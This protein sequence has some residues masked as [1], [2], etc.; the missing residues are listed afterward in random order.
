M[1]NIE[2]LGLVAAVFTTSSFFP[3]VYKAWKEKSTKDISLTMYIAFLI[4]I[5]L[6]L[7]YGYYINSISMVIANTVTLVLVLIVIVLKFKYK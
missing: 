7:I 3:Q 6:W 5:I 2:I 4:G 1:K